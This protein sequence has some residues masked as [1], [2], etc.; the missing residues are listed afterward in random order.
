MA[1]LKVK[2][3]NNSLARGAILLDKHNDLDC[4]VTGAGEL[5]EQQQDMTTIAVQRHTQVDI[6]SGSQLAAQNKRKEKARIAARA[7]RTQ[8]AS[9]IMD[10]ANELHITQ[11]KMRRIDKATIVKLAIDYLKAFEILCRFNYTNGSV[12]YTNQTTSSAT[13]TTKLVANS[14]SISGEDG[15]QEDDCNVS[16][17]ATFDQ[18]VD[19][20][21]YQDDDGENQRI[22]GRQYE[23]SNNDVDDDCDD[24]EENNQENEQFGFRGSNE[25]SQ[26]KSENDYEIQN[27]ISTSN[28][29]R[30]ITNDH[31]DTIANSNQLLAKDQQQKQQL[32]SQQQ[33]PLY[34][35]PKLTTTLIFAPKTVE[36]M[37]SHYLMIEKA[38]NGQ[39]SF[40]LKPD[41]DVSDR[42]DLTHLAPQAGDMSIPLEV[43]PLEGI[44]LDE[45]ELVNS[46]LCYQD[47]TTTTTTTHTTPTTVLQMPSRVANT[48]FNNCLQQ[49]QLIQSINY[50]GNQFVSQMPPPTLDG[51][52]S[53][54]L[55]IERCPRES[56]RSLSS[57]PPMKKL[58]A[59]SAARRHNNKQQ[60][61]TFD[62][63]TQN[64]FAEGINCN[65]LSYLGAVD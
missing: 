65:G 25:L 47:T 44:E 39:P 26:L 41:D 34:S 27:D 57:S 51:C 38:N 6:V 35:A 40:I 45:S 16:A 54:K 46:F 49:Q 2:T 5:H 50:A 42:D 8:E 4:V 17:E 11:E 36:N 30:N 19:D 59:T 15:E 20:E 9:I 33:A 58:Y 60:L 3:S 22:V 24:D 52:T 53:N 31:H 37:N 48:N 29:L 18:L 61:T 62:Y 23:D 43:E 63:A 1:T 64:Y 12:N 10:M 55:M 32:D 13:S 14:N 56:Y 21:H 28:K 7:R